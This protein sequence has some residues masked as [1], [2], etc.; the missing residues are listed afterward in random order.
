MSKRYPTEL[1][2]R[3]MRLAQQTW[4]GHSPTSAALAVKTIAVEPEVGAENLRVWVRQ[5]DL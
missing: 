3:V 4:G 1:C 2:E 5:V